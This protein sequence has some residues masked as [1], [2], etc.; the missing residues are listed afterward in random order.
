MVV[1]LREYLLP[2]L[3]F[4]AT[5]SCAG[6]LIGR[7]LFPAHAAI[8]AESFAKLLRLF[9]SDAIVRR[10]AIGAAAGLAATAFVFFRPKGFFFARKPRAHESTDQ[11]AGA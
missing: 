3:L 8:Q 11:I 6:G 7:V 5:S 2:C 1:R 4:L 10:T 9:A